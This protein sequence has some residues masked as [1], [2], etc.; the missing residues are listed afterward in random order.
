MSTKAPM[1]RPFCILPGLAHGGAVEPCDICSEA[2][3][4]EDLMGMEATP[5]AGDSVDLLLVCGECFHRKMAGRTTF[6]ISEVFYQALHMAVVEKLAS[7]YS[8]QEGEA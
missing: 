2:T 6:Q 1:N 4:I 5:G 7:L 8:S 3:P